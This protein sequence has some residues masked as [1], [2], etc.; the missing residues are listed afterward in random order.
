MKRVFVLL[1]ILVIGL[2]FVACNPSDVVGDDR[3]D[4]QI[5]DDVFERAKEYTAPLF[6]EYLINQKIVDYEI[7]QTNYGVITEEPAIFV[8]GYQYI[9]DGTELLYGYK[10]KLNDNRSFVVLTEGKAVGEF[11]MR[12]ERMRV[13]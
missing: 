8:V 6:R 13:D 9:V 11:L 3:S 7:T 4:I 10:L 2:T 12:S 5:V 1:S